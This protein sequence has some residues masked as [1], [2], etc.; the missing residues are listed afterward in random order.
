[1]KPR[2]CA[3]T[4][5]DL[6]RVYPDDV[7]RAQLAQTYRLQIRLVLGELAVLMRHLRTQVA[8]EVYEQEKAAHQLIEAWVVTEPTNVYT[9][10]RSLKYLLRR[11]RALA[12]APGP[13]AEA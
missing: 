7:L 10:E 5:S 8:A 11:Q 13:G 12:D 4:W 9:L 6:M 2:R 1:M 3:A